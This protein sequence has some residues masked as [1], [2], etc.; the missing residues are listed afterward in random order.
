MSVLTNERRRRVLLMYLEFAHKDLEVGR[1]LPAA[2][3]RALE[4]WGKERFD[5][6]DRLNALGLIPI[7]E[8]RRDIKGMNDSP[9]LR[10]GWTASEERILMN[11]WCELGGELAI[12]R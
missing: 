10:D 2:F 11:G 5:Q 4:I 1:A 3:V 7:V 6:I 12:K 9:R 8:R